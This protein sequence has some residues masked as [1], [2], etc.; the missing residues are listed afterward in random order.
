MNCKMVWTIKNVL[1]WTTQYFAK[2]GIDSP[3][4]DAELLLAQVL[5]CNRIRLYLDQDKTLEPK[6]LQ[7]MHKLVERRGKHE[8]V[9]YI[10]GSKGFMTDDFLVTPAVLVPRP[11]TELLV[12]QAAKFFKDEAICFLDMGTGSGAIAISLLKLLPEARGVAADISKEALQVAQQN[13]VKIGVAERLQFVQSDLY[14]RVGTERFDLLISN[15]PY[16][17]D[18]DMAVLDLDVRQEPRLALAGGVDGWGLYRRI[19]ADAAQ[20]LTSDGVLAF[21]F[22][23]GQAEP[24]RQMLLD[25][26]YAAVAVTRDYAGLERDIFATGKDGKYAD[27]ILAINK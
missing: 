11:E 8:P 7:A 2:L 6:E 3:R 27:R 13:A 5:Q 22:G 12:E 1:Q 14:Q 25:N 26:G 20:H 15:P 18:E 16:I 17:S 9:A 4:V 23:M 21:E 19:I 24:V 10:L